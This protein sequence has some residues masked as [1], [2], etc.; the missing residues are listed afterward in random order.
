MSVLVGPMPNGWSAAE[1][2]DGMTPPSARRKHKLS[3]I[4][5]FFLDLRCTQ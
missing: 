3:Q 5:F 4:F 1:Q 2:D